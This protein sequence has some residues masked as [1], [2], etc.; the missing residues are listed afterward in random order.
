VIVAAFILTWTGALAYFKLGHV[1]QRWSAR[2]GGGD[3][4]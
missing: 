2:A 4:R 3:E 1:E